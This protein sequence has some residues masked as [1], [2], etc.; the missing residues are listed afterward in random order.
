[1]H[2]ASNCREEI[3]APNVRFS[4]GLIVLCMLS[5]SCIKPNSPEDVAMEEGGG[6][7][8]V[9]KF[10][11][12]GYAQ[13]IV[14]TDSFAYMAQGQ[15]GVAIINV[16]D[17]AHPR[18]SSELLYEIPG[19]SRKVAYVKDSAGTEVVFSADGAYGAASVD[20]SDKLHPTVPRRNTGMK[21]SISFFVFK[22]FLF[23]TIS[24]DGVAIADISDPKYPTPVSNIQLPGF[25]KAV[26]VSVDSVYMLLAVGEGGFVMENISRLATGLEIPDTLSGR[27]DLPGQ[28]EDI[29]IVPNTKYACLACGTA[30]LQIVDYADTAHIKLVGSFATGGY[31]K[32]VCVAGDRAYLA[33]ELHG[34]QIIDISDVASPKRIGIVKTTEARGITVANGYVYVADQYEGL[35]IIKI[36]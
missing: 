31:A 34:V 26:C 10:A 24:A 11:T 30:G 25:G 22:K 4:T 18:L 27:L 19:Y 6:Y 20:V 28:A 32:E 5:A 3:M 21:P 35:I 13:D 36:P 14:V 8:V 17:P 1:M 33:T 7:V 29:A 16:A 2:S 23:C 12:T 9:A 15:G